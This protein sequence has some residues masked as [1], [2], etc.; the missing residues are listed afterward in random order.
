M[1]ERERI[2]D[3]YSARVFKNRKDHIVE[4]DDSGMP[5]QIAANSRSVPGLMVN[6][7]CCYAGCKGVVLGPL[8]DVVVLTHGPIGC[9]YYSWGTRRNKGRAEDGRNFMQ[10]CF[11]T[12]MQEPDIVFGGEK[13]LKQAIKEIVEIFHPEC[14][15]ICSTCPVGL[16]GDDTSAVAKWAEETYKVKCVAYSCEGY[17]GVS[18]SAGHHIANN[19]LMKHIIGSGNAKPDK[20]FA[21]NI[22]GEYNIGGDG[23]ESERLLKLI[24][25]EVISVFTG[26]G[27]YEKIKNAHVANLNLLQCHRSISYIAEMMKTKYNIDWIKINFIGI[28]ETIRS[29]REVAA[30]FNDPGINARTEEVIA[31]EL[32][33]I[34]EDREY[35]REKLTGKTA[36]I[37][38]GGSRSHHYQNLLADFGIK[39]L[40]A[41][42]EFAHRDDYEGREVIPDIKLDADTKNIEQLTV[43]PDNRYYHLA[44][45]KE[46][47]D[48][49]KE[50]TD[51]EYYAGMFKDMGD[52]TI[53]VDD[54]NHYE[55]EKLLELFKPDIFYS[56]IKDKYMIQKS[57]TPS[58][59]LHSYDYSGPY[60][61]FKGAI[62]FA[63]DTYMSIFTP[64]W[65]YITPP[66]YSKPTL[67]GRI[68]AEAI[69]G[70]EKNA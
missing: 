40:V 1:N 55:T 32:E 58:R 35:Y 60:A 46:H 50:K 13:K 22:L 66:W 10:Y 38:V 65:N 31:S 52:G 70:G 23:W 9:G 28:D 47:F 14:I 39:T 51:L 57:G 6:R 26:D 64:A 8:H 20:K 7:G 41:G 42:Y 43:E 18:Q 30:Y 69:A 59:Q 19:G 33:E 49:L 16:I 3:K 53:T 11:S 62:N 63:R 34:E 36:G 37:F 21:I 56:G 68:G 29:L 24:G 25:Y 4:L 2:L 12:D 45:D 5:K 44:I 54:F 17:K 61:C 15:M 27:S 48:A 67:E